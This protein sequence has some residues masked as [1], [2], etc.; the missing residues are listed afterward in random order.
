MVDGKNRELTGK[1]L[2]SLHRVVGSLDFIPSV[3]GGPCKVLIG[4]A[5]LCGFVLKIILEEIMKVRRAGRG[6][7]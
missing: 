2:Q 4:E 1:L 7:Y 6:Y 3:M 5:L